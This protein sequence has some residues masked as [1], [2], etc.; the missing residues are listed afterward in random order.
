M[1]VDDVEGNEDG[2][3]H[4]PYLPSAVTAPKKPFC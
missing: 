3:H 4:L 1:R 2:E